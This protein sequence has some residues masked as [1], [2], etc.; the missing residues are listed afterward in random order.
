MFLG[1]K[2]RCP[3]AYFTLKMSR[4]PAP[5]A[6]GALSSRNMPSEIEIPKTLVLLT[7]LE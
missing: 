6:I 7:K 3:E 4:Y 1:L 5:D 2:G